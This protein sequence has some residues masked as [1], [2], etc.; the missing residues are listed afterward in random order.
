MMARA[1]AVFANGG[2]LPTTHS[3]RKIVDASGQ[4]VVDNSHPTMRQNHI[5]KVAQEM[6]EHDDRNV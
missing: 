6:T 5:K 4:T 3:I 2:K 1:Y